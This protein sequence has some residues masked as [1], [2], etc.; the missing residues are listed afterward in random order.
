MTNKIIVTALYK[1]CL[2]GY[3]ARNYFIASQGMIFFIMET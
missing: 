2:Q 1:L 3:R